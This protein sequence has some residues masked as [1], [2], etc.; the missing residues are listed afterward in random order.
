MEK[1][2]SRLKQRK[3]LQIL[4]IF[5]RYLLGAA[6]V[7]AS[8]FKIVG[9]RFTPKSGEKAP[10]ASL[11]H[12]LE[13]MYQSGIYWY[14]IGW[15]QLLAGFLVMSQIFSTLGAVTFFPIMLNIFI[16]TIKFEHPTIFLI[17]SLMLLANFYLLLW[18]WNKLK[19]V[20]LP[21]PNFY[22]ENNAEFLRRKVWVYVGVLFF[23]ILV[24]LRMVK[25]KSSGYL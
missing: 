21:E 9:I 25:L 22:S 3:I 5:L 7:H 13:A 24:F 4:T 23:L 15:G 19:F 8:I 2:I 1:L 6:F 11:A 18:D 20:V 14:F 10:I 17:T 12:F 16:I